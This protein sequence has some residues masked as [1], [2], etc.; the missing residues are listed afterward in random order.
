MSDPQPE[1]GPA[2]EPDTFSRTTIRVVIGVLVALC[3]ARLLLMIL[4]NGGW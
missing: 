1:P 2:R 3:A 4:T